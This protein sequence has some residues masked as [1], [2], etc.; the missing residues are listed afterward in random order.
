MKSSYSPNIL[1]TKSNSYTKLTAIRAVFF[2]ITSIL[3]IV[4]IYIMSYNFFRYF[5]HWGMIFDVIYFGSGVA[6]RMSVSLAKYDQN[7]YSMLRKVYRIAY[8]V[9]WTINWLISMVYWLIL[10]PVAMFTDES[11]NNKEWT[12]NEILSSVFDYCSHIIPL[13]GV[14][15]DMVYNQML[16]MPSHALY[17]ILLI[18]LYGLEDAIMVYLG[19]DVS[20]PDVLTWNDWITVGALLGF[21]VIALIAFYVGY[22]L[23][24]KKL[25]ANELL[26][27]KKSEN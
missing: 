13:L 7:Q 10:F 11:D 6:I 26:L 12:L 4:G 18:L 22:K 19:Y 27:Q 23:S 25:S 16:F 20:Y 9:G 5:T 8:E 1:Q 15:L 14:V 24:Q 17:C 3:L 2:L 21:I